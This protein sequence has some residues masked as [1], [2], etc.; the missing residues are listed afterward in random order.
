[1]IYAASGK[2]IVFDAPNIPGY[3]FLGL[4]A[5]NTLIDDDDFILNQKHMTNSRKKFLEYH[6]NTYLKK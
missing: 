4:Y 5:N 3:N 6:R 2:K 1:M